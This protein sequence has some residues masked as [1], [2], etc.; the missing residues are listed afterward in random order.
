MSK[1]GIIR[2]AQIDEPIP[3]AG[4]QED[5]HGVESGRQH[6]GPSVGHQ[7]RFSD[8][9]DVPDAAEDRIPSDEIGDF[10]AVDVGGGLVEVDEVVVC[11]MVDR[12][13]EALEAGGVA[14][15]GGDEIGEGDGVGSIGFGEVEGSDGGDRFG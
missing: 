9:P 15:G 11:G 4:P 8:H 7:A 13:E 14:V 5:G 3:F 12:R 10:V 6:G 2:G 1:Q